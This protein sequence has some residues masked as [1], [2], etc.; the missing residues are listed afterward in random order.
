MNRIIYIM[1]VSGSGKT[2]IGEMLS[3]KTGTPFFDADDFHSAANKEK[4]KAGI[5]LTDEDRKTWLQ[6]IDK[7]ADGQQHLKGA[8]IACSA[9]K[10]KYRHTLTKNIAAP[11]FIFLQGDYNVILA[12]I[13]NRKEHF[14]PPQLLASQF[15]SLE[16]PAGA[17]TISIDK[18]P[19]EIV[20]C[21][22]KYLKEKK[23]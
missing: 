1:G 6:Q 17:F 12:R 7:L 4:M 13:K 18:K 15:A 22:L 21:I 8:V 20:D 11:E 23:I 2:T 16:I 14:M 3:Q 10:E 19:E 9:L 5:P